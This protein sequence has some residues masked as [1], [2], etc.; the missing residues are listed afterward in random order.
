[1]GTRRI[2]LVGAA[3]TTAL[4]AA[5][6]QGSATNPDS[7]GTAAGSPVTIKFQSL[8]DQP[9]AVEAVKGIV[10]SW[11]TSH[12]E[13]KVELIQAGWD[14]VYDKLVTQFN[15]NAA[16]DVIHYEAASIVP[17]ARDGYL[18]DLTSKVPA[19][20][21]SDVSDGI[22]KSV[23]VDNKIVGMPTE[24]QTYVVFANKKLLEASGATIPTGDSMTFQQ[25]Q[26]L[27]K[28]AT[29]GGSYGLAWGLKSPTAT[30]MGLGLASGGTFF[31][32][33]GKDAKINVG[34]GELALPKLVKQMAYTDKSIDPV[35]LTQSGSQALASFYA[36]K[37]AMTVQGSFQAANIKKD[38]PAG[39]DW[40][41]LPP[42]AG[43]QGTDQAAN[44]QT[45]SVNADSPNVDKAAEFVAYFAGAENMA[46]LN[47]ADAL[48]PAS[49]KAQDM[50]LA[51]TGGKDGWDMTMKSAQGLT[52]A[53]FLAV[54]AY[55]QWK[56]TVATPN[57][58]KYLANQVDDAG[59]AQALTEGF[60]QVN[61]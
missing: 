27:A 57:F 5:C 58:Q 49:K 18:A 4:L 3:I 14:G 10:D 61:R 52:G 59:L 47:Q 23:T 29:K 50:I 2:A 25:L 56:D 38:A 20:L 37:A 54:D 16:P 60:R 13:A 8:Q 28:G 32:G 34:E 51:S 53:P 40:V 33:T 19:D 36:G 11:N 9:A 6:S 39:M 48:I 44:P 26:A 35:S 43:S 55:T 41:E 30:F 7:G 45:L 1:M 15:G 22:W 17:F 21:K 42:L 31:T 12:P 24:L 46:K